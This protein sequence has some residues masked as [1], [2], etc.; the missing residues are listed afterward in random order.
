MPANFKRLG[1]LLVITWNQTIKIKIKNISDDVSS[2]YQLIV[3]RLSSQCF[4]HNLIGRLIL[5]FSKDVSSWIEKTKEIVEPELTKLEPNAEHSL[6]LIVWMMLTLQSK[7]HAKLF[8][9]QY[10]QYGATALR[11]KVF[12]FIQQMLNNSVYTVSKRN[13][14]YWKIL[15]K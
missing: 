11:M 14:K 13:I 15:E 2:K 6:M 7:T 3:L 4:K 10:Q 9:S 12:V 5:Y 1:N 8:E